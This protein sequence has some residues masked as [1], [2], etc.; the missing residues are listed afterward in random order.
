[1]EMRLRTRLGFT[2]IE[3]LVVIAIIAILAAILFP[4]FAK[5][6]DKARQAACLS[7]AK[8]MALAT[9]QYV[10]DYDEMFPRVTV[11]AYGAKF[12]YWIQKGYGLVYPLEPYMKSVPV[13]KCPSQRPRTIASYVNAG[14][15][16]GNYSGRV[17]GAWGIRCG[18][19]RA[20]GSFDCVSHPSYE[21]GASIAEIKAPASIISVQETCNNMDPWGLGGT[22]WG[23]D[24]GM[25]NGLYTPHHSD[26]A[27]LVFCD[28]HAKWYSMVNHPC[29][30]SPTGYPVDLTPPQP[31][32]YG[33]TWPERQISFDITYQP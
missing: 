22:F 12:S 26:G 31:Y 10:Q 28:G 3:L 27:N 25:A 6:R 19:Q 14:A 7:N 11:N 9:L 5:A 15:Y 16:Q 33:F 2:L 17:P 8:Q 30:L 1:M 21:G 13:L 23:K 20:D 24:A 18:D 29:W 32:T 4:V